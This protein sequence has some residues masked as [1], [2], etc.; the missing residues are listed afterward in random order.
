MTVLS[1][2]LFSIGSHHLVVNYKFQSKSKTQLWF[3]ILT[4]V[5]IACSTPMLWWDINITL[6]KALRVLFCTNILITCG[7]VL[8]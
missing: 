2:V 1:V 8:C 6:H 4:L 7:Y 3:Y 5:S